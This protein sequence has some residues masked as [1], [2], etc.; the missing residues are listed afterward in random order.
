MAETKS[1]LVALKKVGKEEYFHFVSQLEVGLRYCDDRHLVFDSA[2]DVCYFCDADLLSLGF[3][4]LFSMLY[5]AV[6]P[7]VLQREE[8]G[9]AALRS[10]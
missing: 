2:S 3:L 7:Q 10:F 5:S 9:L 1:V 6:S 4:L 8:A